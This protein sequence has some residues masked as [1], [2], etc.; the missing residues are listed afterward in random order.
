[1]WNSISIKFPPTHSIKERNTAPIR[2][3]IKN[4]LTFE[5]VNF[6]SKNRKLK[7]MIRA[8]IP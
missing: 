6:F 1:M 7:R 2:K 5:S 4:L 8:P 3:V